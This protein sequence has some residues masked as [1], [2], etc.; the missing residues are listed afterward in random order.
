MKWLY[1]QPGLM[2]VLTWSEWLMMTGVCILF[3]IAVVV[4][5]KFF[6]IAFSMMRGE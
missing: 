5:I 2:E 6:R 4:I 1:N 3:G